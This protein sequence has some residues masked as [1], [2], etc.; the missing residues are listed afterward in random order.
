MLD[1]GDHYAVRLSNGK[2]FLVDKIDLYFIEAN[3]WYSCND[4]A[5]CKQ[6]N[7]QVRFHNLILG[8]TPTNDSLIDHINQNPLDNRRKKSKGCIAANTENKSRSMTHGNSTW[9]YF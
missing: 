2:E 7:K 4:Y 3:I 9:G 1:R 8:H 5:S 6:N